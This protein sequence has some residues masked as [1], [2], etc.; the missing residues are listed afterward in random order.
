MFQAISAIAFLHK[1]NLMHRD[2]KP[3][4]FL[5]QGNQEYGENVPN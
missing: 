1:S 4:N 2:I 5:V 3:E